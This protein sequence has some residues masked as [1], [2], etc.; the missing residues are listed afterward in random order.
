MTDKIMPNEIYVT[1]FGALIRTRCEKDK[2]T[3]VMIHQ[4]VV[5]ANLAAGDAV[6]IQVFNHEMTAVLHFAEY[7]V[8]DRRTAMKRIEVNDRESK[9]FE[10]V[11]FAVMK[12]RDWRDTPA[13]PSSSP[14]D[15]MIVRSK[16][17]GRFD[18]EDASGKVVKSFTK[19]DGG[20]E[21]AE[22][23]ARGAEK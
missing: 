22:A 20:K 5:A 9:Q 4:R 16:G 12:V 6:R 15:G 17:F 13:A 21:S 7:L 18:V 3:D 10:D 19:E 11:S 1:E 2:I 23:F 14:A 8:F